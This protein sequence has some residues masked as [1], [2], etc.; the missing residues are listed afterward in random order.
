MNY[1]MLQHKNNGNPTISDKKSVTKEKIGK[2]D[3]L[4][5]EFT[6]TIFKGTFPL[7]L[8]HVLR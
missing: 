3:Y 1:I 7:S 8:W 2:E 4:N 5:Y 6:S